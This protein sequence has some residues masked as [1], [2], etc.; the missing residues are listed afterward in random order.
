MQTLPKYPRKKLLSKVKYHWY[1]YVARGGFDKPRATIEPL[2]KGGIEHWTNF[3]HTGR[4]Y[5]VAYPHAVDELLQ[6]VPKAMLPILT[7]E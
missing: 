1:A 5:V 7:G 3:L 6:F 4:Q 2:Q